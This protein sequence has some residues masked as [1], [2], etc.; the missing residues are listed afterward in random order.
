MFLI[1]KVL[2]IVCRLSIAC[3]NSTYGCQAV[4]KLDSLQS[5]LAEC[6]HNPKKPVPCEQGCG[7]IIPMDEL[8]VTFLHFIL[9][10]IFIYTYYIIIKD[11]WYFTVR[12]Q[13]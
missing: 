7:L 11:D 13:F 10:K 1:F 12:I 4:L 8:K 3:E 2:Y 6:E 5:H 9:T